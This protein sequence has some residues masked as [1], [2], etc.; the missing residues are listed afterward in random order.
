MAGI[1]VKDMFLIQ[2]IWGYSSQTGYTCYNY[3]AINNSPS[4]LSYCIFKVLTF[5]SLFLF[6]KWF[7]KRFEVILTRFSHDNTLSYLDQ[8]Y[9]IVVT[10]TQYVI[11]PEGFCRVKYDYPAIERKIAEKVGLGKPRIPDV[12]GIPQV[13]WNKGVTSL[14]MKMHA[15]RKSKT[16]VQVRLIICFVWMFKNWLHSLLRVPVSELY[17]ALYEWLHKLTSF[18]VI[19]VGTSF[20]SSEVW[21]IV[22]FEITSNVIKYPWC[23]WAG[24]YANSPSK[25]QSQKAFDNLH[26]KRSSYA[27]QV[28]S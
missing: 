24:N 11:T 5:L 14:R 15:L 9:T 10:H 23:Y 28:S 16:L 8:V 20:T 26:R 18:I 13:I 25:W 17:S 12:T 22:W 4:S 3:T 1:S 21:Y 7:G 2:W 27:R 19:H 6:R